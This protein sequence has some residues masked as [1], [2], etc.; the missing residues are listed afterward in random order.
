MKPFQESRVAMSSWW[1]AILL[2]AIQIDIAFTQDNQYRGKFL[3][4]MQPNKSTELINIDVARIQYT[5]PYYSEIAQDRC[6][7]IH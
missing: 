4:Y 7:I 5:Y 6:N 2:I 3:F 1:I